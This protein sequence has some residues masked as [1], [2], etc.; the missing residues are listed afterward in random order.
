MGRLF[1]KR[2]ASGGRTARASLG[3]SRGQCTRLGASRSVVLASAGFA[4]LEV[5]ISVG[6]LATGALAVLAVNSALIATATVSHQRAQASLLAQELVVMVTTDATQAGCYATIGNTTCPSTAARARLQDWQD[7]VQS[8]LPGVLADGGISAEFGADRSFVVT[9]QWRSAR[10]TETRN[11]RL[12][13]H[14]GG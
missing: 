4:L 5:L 9:V 10:S 8:S 12:A 6:L 2:Q 7:R 14:L 3:W 13:T 11:L 1:M